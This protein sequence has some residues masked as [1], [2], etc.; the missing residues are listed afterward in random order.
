MA[1]D[2]RRR[3]TSAALASRQGFRRTLCCFRAHMHTYATPVLSLS[4]PIKAPAGVH[5]QTD[6]FFIFLPHAPRMH[7]EHTCALDEYLPQGQL[8]ASVCCHIS[9]NAAR[10][11]LW[12]E[13]R[14]IEV[15]TAS[16]SYSSA[17]K[18]IRKYNWGKQV[19]PKQQKQAALLVLQWEKK[20]V[21]LWNTADLQP[22]DHTS[23]MCLHNEDVFCD[24][25]RTH[26]ELLE[27]LYFPYSPCPCSGW[28]WWEKGQRT[29]HSA[30][31]ERLVLDVR[32]VLNLTQ[33][34]DELCG[35][36]WLPSFLQIDFK[37]SC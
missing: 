18:N 37:T 8:W 20:G 24:A 6:S 22:Q 25:T 5:T 16:F 23:K 28:M 14:T 3:P 32:N 15:V 27:L 36:H 34:I 31:T 12:M 13:N 19:K 9:E 29:G 2:G 21:P 11:V 1:H 33:H 30:P 7:R 26:A 17:N 10:M 4:S 35:S